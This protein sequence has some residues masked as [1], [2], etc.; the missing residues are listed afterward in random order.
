MMMETYAAE[1]M[2]YLTTGLIDRGVEDYSVE[3]AICKVYGSEMLWRVV[4]EALQIAAGIGYMK[5]Y[6]VRAPAA[7]RAHQPHLRGHQRDPALL[8][9]AVR[10]AGPGR[11]AGAAGRGHQVAAQGLRPAIDFVVDKLKTQYYGGERLDHVHPSL[12][13][14]AVLFED[15]VPELAK[16]V[17]KVLRKHGKEISEMQYVQRRIADIAIDLYMMIACIV[18]HDRGAHRARARGRARGQAVPRGL[19]PRRA[20]HQAQHPHVR[21]QRRR[22]AQGHRQGRLRRRCDY[23]FDVVLGRSREMMTD[24]QS[25]RSRLRRLQRRSMAD[26]VHARLLL[27]ARRRAR[28]HLRGAARSAAT[29][30]TSRATSSSRALSRRPP[31]CFR[32]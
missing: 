30:R 24:R 5:E 25:L 13:R 16:D 29:C 1:S 22:A 8:H 28:R 19:R 7:R 21:R 23:P 18:A 9:R 26:R 12:K 15:W 27:S 17:E 4:N 31:R 10:H 6:P 14:E 11:S 32:R 20:A 2:V 3:S